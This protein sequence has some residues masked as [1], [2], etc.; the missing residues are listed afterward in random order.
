[1][2][3]RLVTRHINDLEKAANV[4]GGTYITASE[5]TTPMVLIPVR[6][7]CSFYLTIPE[8]FY[9]LIS[10]HGRYVGMWDSGFHFARPWEKIS[11]LVTCQFVVYDTPVK[12]CPTSDNVMVEIDV[13]IVFHIKENEESVKNFVWRLGPERL[14][15]MLRAFQEEAVRS[16]VR[17]KKYSNI[18]DLMDTD[19]IDAN[20]ERKRAAAPE[21]A[22]AASVAFIDAERQGVV[23]DEEKEQLLDNG[24]VDAS[25]AAAA[26]AAAANDGLDDHMQQLE[27]TKRA[28]NEELGK[29]GID[30]YSI[31][32]TNVHLPPEISASMENATTFDSKNAMQKEQQN[33][34]LLVVADNAS[35][36][37][38][39][40]LMGEE[41]EAADE[42]NN[43]NVSLQQK[44]TSL[45]HA[46]TARVIADVK[47]Q[48]SASVL[49]IQATSN[50]EVSELTKQKELELAAIDAAGRAAARKIASEAEAFS[51]SET[52]KADV[53][54]AQNDAESMR[55]VAAA[56]ATVAQQ[57][58]W[59]RDFDAQMAHL[60]AL[61]QLAS[62][63]N[64]AL[65]GTNQ[66][67]IVAQLVGAKNGG[68]SLGLN[69]GGGQ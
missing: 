68:E 23:A 67:S 48:E 19:E 47:E 52:A 20:T 1:M 13:S 4:I 64:F 39:R 57:L 55:I 65:T 29:Y 56:E 17:R 5:K 26:A 12:E 21:T 38:S 51:L 34:T 10:S 61:R 6:K 59:K 44:Q 42:T 32:I 63:P 37:K 41:K 24:H 3:T 2:H 33:H 36:A 22:T 40:Q 8:G 50:L 16:M 14:E 9:A 45:V 53:A 58:T 62:N 54:V 49:R 18:Y 35:Q 15:S 46:E 43:K 30:V 25:K 28:M 60:T 27:N 7:P 69:I 31:T 11:H 66:D